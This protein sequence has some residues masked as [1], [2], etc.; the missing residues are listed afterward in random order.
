MK[1]A[2]LM[3]LTLSVLLACVLPTGAAV[4]AK[5]ETASAKADAVSVKADAGDENGEIVLAKPLLSPGLNVLA[6]KK[7]MIR[8]GVGTDEICFTSHD[9]E[10]TL[11]YLPAEITVLSLP[12]PKAGILKLGALDLQAGQ[13]LSVQTLSSLRFVPA[14]NG[15]TEASFTFCASGGAYLTD[16][17]RT[18]L[19]CMT[20]AENNPPLARD[21]SAAAYCDIPVQ[22]TLYGCDPDE[23]DVTFTVIRAPRKG[24]VTLN[25]QT[26]AFVYT[27]AAGKKGKDT[28]TYRVSD[29]YGNESD[30]CRV[31]VTVRKPSVSVDYADLD[32]H[33]AQTA[34][35]AAA[36]AGL[37]LG[38]NVGGTML[39][40]PD[41]SVTRAEF[42][43]MAMRAAGYTDVP[44]CEKTVFADNAQIPAYRRGYLQSAYDMGVTSGV[45][46][47]ENGLPVFAPDSVITRA[48]A[49]VLLERLL[50]LSDA[51]N[52]ARAV[53]SMLSSSEEASVPAWSLGAVH[54]LSDAGILSGTG[55]GFRLDAPLDR[56]QTAQ[57][58]AGTLRWLEK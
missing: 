9:F 41:K 42:L 57:L 6:G 53:V 18:C 10:K 36:E 2:V 45:G 13:T 25:A 44:A 54:A 8:S 23:D 43:V 49:V 38:E 39:F 3:L 4:S 58:L 56:A 19:L 15:E 32:G 21:A 12:D 46:T 16:T 29:R 11:G 51:E 24:E 28:F 1:K 47:D 20:E 33:W 55:D 31:E 22:G 14:G 37:M 52:G 27:P 50:G 40:S 17:A 7:T 35:V 48:E 34:A 30:V 26:G 5:T